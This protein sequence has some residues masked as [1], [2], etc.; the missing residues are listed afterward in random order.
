MHAATTYTDK[1]PVIYRELARKLVNDGQEV[2]EPPHQMEQLKDD[3]NWLSVEITNVVFEYLIPETQ[4]RLLEEVEPN[5]PWAEMHFLERVSGEPMNPPPSAEIWPYAQRGNEDHLED[6]KFS[7]TYPERMWPKYA[8]EPMVWPDTQTWGLRY[9]L[10]DL[11]D[12]VDLIAKEPFTRQAYL[13]IWFPE[14]IT[15]ANKGKRVPCTLGY[16]FLMREG[17]LNMTYFIRSC[18]FVRYFRDDVYMACRL[19]QWVC[20]ELND[21][22]DGNVF[23]TEVVDGEKLYSSVVPGM[24]TMHIVSLHCFE[25]DLGRLRG[26]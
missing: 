8:G 9:R 19:V 11:R 6:G 21:S 2:N 12:L 23:V 14:D 5:V 16:H 10:G 26:A 22:T 24:L 13:P 18:D 3:P 17:V 4:E 7:H 15:A 20:N 25:G 1:F